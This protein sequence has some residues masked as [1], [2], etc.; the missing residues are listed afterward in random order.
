MQKHNKM[1]KSAA[2][3]SLATKKPV[4]LETNI[5]AIRTIIK[6]AKRQGDDEMV[7]RAE[8][9]L[10]K[11]IG[12]QDTI[13]DNRFLECLRKYESILTEKN[14]RKTIAQRIRGAVSRNGVK[15]TMINLAKKAE[16][17]F[18]FGKLIQAGEAKATI[19]YLITEMK[20]QFDDAILV[21][22]HSKLRRAGISCT[23]LR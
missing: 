1:M 13:L 12:F 4:E 16:P 3:K 10:A 8:A 22:A 7:A 19:E 2:V 23:S 11:F 14:D 6:N 15:Q 21:A 18:G 9:H 17:S 5:G 20:D